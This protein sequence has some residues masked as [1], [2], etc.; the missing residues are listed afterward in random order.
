MFPL[1]DTIVSRHP[2]IAT[3][4]L[5][6]LNCLV[7]FLELSL[8]PETLQQV[9]YLLGIVPARFTHPVWA[10]GVGFPLGAYWTLLT[11][12]FLHAGWFHLFG[13]MWTLWIFGDNV[14]DQMGPFR[15]V[16]F[17]LLCG[18]LAGVVHLTTNP[19]STIPTIGASGAIAGVM[20]AYLVMFPQARIIVLVPIFIFPFFFDMSAFFYLGFWFFIQFFSG[21]AA[22]ASPGQVGGIAFWAHVGGFLSGIL[23][24]GFFL[25][26]LGERRP[27]A[28]D[29]GGVERAWVRHW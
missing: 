16:L 1:Q 21:T 14:E 10:Q 9:T 6:G 24:F 12:M 8:P 13:N 23:A 27:V 11:T 17:Y 22:I 19:D 20:G 28:A 18:V 29:E 4:A 26:P 25:R 2:P 3:W 7:F 15:F 5:I